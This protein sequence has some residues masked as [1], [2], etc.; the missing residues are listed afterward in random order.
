[1][2]INTFINQVEKVIG[3][4]LILNS[5]SMFAIIAYISTVLN[6]LRHAYLPV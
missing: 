3:I 5:I 4:I 6:H 1:M 2:H